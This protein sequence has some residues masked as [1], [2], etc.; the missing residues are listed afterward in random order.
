MGLQKIVPCDRWQRS[1]FDDKILNFGYSG[2]V[3]R[4]RK[5]LTLHEEVFF[6]ILNEMAMFD[7]TIAIWREKK[8]WDA[9]RPFSAIK[10]LYGDQ[11]ITSYCGK[12]QGT[13]KLPASDWASY[14]PA[15][16]H[17]EYPSASAAI[18]SAK[19]EAS[20]SFLAMINSHFFLFISTRKFKTGKRDHTE[21]KTFH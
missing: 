10:Y 11:N 12:G 5:N 3:S 1:F 16:N 2:R 8:R 19:A 15:A 9:V 18:C 21:K 17:P 20:V 14:M 13:C 4:T 6:S 7:T